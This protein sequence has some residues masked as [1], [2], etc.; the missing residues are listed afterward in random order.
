MAA[1]ATTGFVGCSMEPS[2]DS[3]ADE[4]S[5]PLT[6]LPDAVALETILTGIRPPVAGTFAPDTDCRYVAERSG[7]IHVHEADGPLDEPFLDLRD[8]IEAGGKQGLLGV[9]LHPDFA[10][11]RRMFVRYS[12]PSRPRTPRTTATRS[13]CRNSR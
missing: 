3:G 13:S 12:S 2:D 9:A 10:E 7:R 11:N 4:R 6:D 1:G 5:E 8:S